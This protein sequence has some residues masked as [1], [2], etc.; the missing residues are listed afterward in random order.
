MRYS[1]IINIISF[2]LLQAFTLLLIHSGVKA[3]WEMPK[4]AYFTCHPKEIFKEV[5][6][7]C[8]D[9]ICSGKVI[10]KPDEFSYDIVV[11]FNGIDAGFFTKRELSE[12]P[13]ASGY[14]YR[15]QLTR[16]FIKEREQ[17]IQ[18]FINV[19]KT[20]CQ[21]QISADNT[22]LIE[23]LHDWTEDPIDDLGL[24]PNTIQKRI[25]I[26]KECGTTYSNVDGWLR[27]LRP[28]EANG[29]PT[30]LGC[31]DKSNII[32]VGVLVFLIALFILIITKL[33]IKSYKKAKRSRT[34]TNAEIN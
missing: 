1:F 13:E 14:L 4:Y 12:T 33:A 30:P 27:Y 5:H 32:Q 2:I 9:D 31:I 25:E 11:Q 21:E 28:R 10:S 19:A 15:F 34:D 7:E 26:S 6:E 23:T 16:E 24:E 29:L 18:D 3:D 20:V 22:D 8:I 17:G